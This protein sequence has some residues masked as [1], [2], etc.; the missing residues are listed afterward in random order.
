MYSLPTIYLLFALHTLYP[1]YFFPPSLPFSSYSMVS[2]L[3][4]YI[5]QISS[6]TKPISKTNPTTCLLLQTLYFPDFYRQFSFHDRLQKHH[7]IKLNKLRFFSLLKDYDTTQREI[8]EYISL[9]FY[10]TKILTKKWNQ[11]RFTWGKK[12]K[13]GVI[14]VGYG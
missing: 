11:K 7:K 6:T 4:W 12:K 2:H 9:K 13:C 8:K 10:G 14:I 5:Q 3:F 1:S